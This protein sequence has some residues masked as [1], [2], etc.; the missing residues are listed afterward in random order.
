MTTDQEHRPSPDADVPSSASE[1]G[2]QT[3]PSAGQDTSEAGALRQR[4]QER[5]QA[6]ADLETQLKRM[7]ADFENFRRRSSAEREN[8][9]KYAGERILER[10]LEPLDNFERALTAN[11]LEDCVHRF[12]V[13]AG[14]SILVHSGQVHA[15]DAGNLILEI[16]Q[17]SD[18][19]YR[20]YDWGRVGLDGQRHSPRRQR[21]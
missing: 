17:N 2:S 7:A 13:A 3:P 15:I 6:Y 5:E 1:A 21:N 14:D 20:V 10:F 9:L 18:T 4:L 16:Q 12:P 8:L 19:T 11:T